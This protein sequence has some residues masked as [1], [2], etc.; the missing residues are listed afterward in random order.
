MRVFDFSGRVRTCAL[1]LAAVWVAISAGAATVPRLERPQYRIYSVC[2]GSF[3]LDP[4]AQTELFARNFSMAQG[5]FTAAE[6][7]RVKAVN[8]DCQLVNYMN[9]TYT[10]SASEVAD[11]EATKLSI[12]MTQAAKLT[13]GID[14][15]ATSFKVTRVVKTSGT[16]VLPIL[17][18]HDSNND[19]RSG[20]TS[21]FVFWIGIGGELMKVTAVAAD[22]TITVARGYAGTA[23]APHAAGD[24]VCG[25][26][27]VGNNTTGGGS[28][29]NFPNG[30]AGYLRYC[31][32][33]DAEPGNAIKL[34]QIRSRLDG[35][36][37]GV[38]LDTCNQ[39]TFNLCDAL[40][41]TVRPWLWARSPAIEYP[42]S[43]FRDAQ[44]RKMRYFQDRIMAAYGRLPRLYANNLLAA[45]MLGVTDPNDPYLGM[46]K[47]IMSTDDK[48]VPID[49]FC[50]EDYFENARD[51]AK[52]QDQLMAIRRLNQLGLATL[53]ILS[54]AGIRAYTLTEV[55]PERVPLEEYGYA[56]YLLAVLP[57][58]ASRPMEFGT[59]AFYTNATTGE[60]KIQVH[61]QYFWPVGVP[62]DAWTDYTAIAAYQTTGVSKLYL[63]K[64]TNGL[65]VLNGTSATRTVALPGAYMDPVTG[66]TGVTSVTLATGTAKIFLQAPGYEQFRALSFDGTE[67]P[68]EAVSGAEADPDGDGLSNL[69]EYATGLNPKV[70]DTAG[71]PPVGVAD[72]HLELTITRRT[73][74]TDLGYRVE[75]SDDL[76]G[77]SSDPADVEQV[78]VEAAGDGLERATYRDTHASTPAAR[79]FIR[80][81]ITLTPQ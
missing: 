8:P 5:S 78:A 39:G 61:D 57:D 54:H 1:P 38:W 25:P 48:P 79:R 51:P 46:S 33:P 41:R 66:E 11:A 31:L 42:K 47:L 14:A 67:Q 64:F 6:I 23:P 58:Q 35:G 18:T 28:T 21:D 2:A 56:C 17:A 26:V 75:V 55:D 7:A 62:Q 59:Y 34:A 40:G 80:L 60:R 15:A 3:T 69:F 43:Q 65:V 27:Y 37:D 53:P 70:A 12:C 19:G 13:A 45:D 36:Y 50:N 68:D 24:V 77:W 74:V 9:S 16:L 22:D 76:A 4:G 32:D 63:R 49:G 81:R 71:L 29:G 52:V 20:S 10:N 72:G 73:D 30:G 44:D